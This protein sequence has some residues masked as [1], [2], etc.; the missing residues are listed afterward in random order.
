MVFE[1]SQEDKEMDDK[2]GYIWVLTSK[3]GKTVVIGKV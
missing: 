3:T 2:S 1:G